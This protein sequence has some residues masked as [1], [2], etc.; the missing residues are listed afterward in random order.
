MN[1]VFVHM[2]Y[3]F[4]WNKG[5][6]VTPSIVI[7]IISSSHDPV[8]INIYFISTDLFILQNTCMLGF[9]LKQAEPSFS[10]D[11]FVFQSIGCHAWALENVNLYFGCFSWCS[12]NLHWR[13]FFFGIGRSVNFVCL[14]AHSDEGASCPT[15][16]LIR[17]SCRWVFWQSAN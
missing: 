5:S 7:P 8:Y 16:S 11:S 6:T 12:H 14:S 15:C 13:D 2:N 3:I 9:L 10:D 17:E 1:I 4:L